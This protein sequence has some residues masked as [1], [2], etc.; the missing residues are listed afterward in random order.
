M[1][2]PP[3]LYHPFSP[4]RNSSAKGV[5]PRSSFK[6][7]YRADFL[8]CFSGPSL[9]SPLIVLHEERGHSRSVDP[10]Q[11]H[12][13]SDIPDDHHPR[14]PSPTS[15]RSLDDFVVL[16]RGTGTSPFIR[17]S[18]GTSASVWTRRSSSSSPPLRTR[19]RP[20]NFWGLLCGSP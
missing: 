19:H 15:C 8:P 18:G 11:I 3:S 17:C 2:H 4:T 1:S 10:Q 16:R 6:R 13:M 12:L 5:H 7:G 9:L 20:E 14:H